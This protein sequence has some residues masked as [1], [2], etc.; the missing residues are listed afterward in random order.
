MEESFNRFIKLNFCSS[1]E[2]QEAKEYYETIAN[3]NNKKFY[4]QTLLRIISLSYEYMLKNNSLDFDFAYPIYHKYGLTKEDF[5][6]YVDYFAHNSF[7]HVLL[8]KYDTI[9]KARDNQI[10]EG[11]FEEVKMVMWDKK[12]I[13]DIAKRHNMTQAKLYRIIDDYVTNVLKFDNKEYKRYKKYYHYYSLFINFSGMDYSTLNKALYYYQNYASAKEK[14]NFVKVANLFLSVIEKMM[15]I[16]NFSYINKDLANVKIREYDLY[17]LA[18]IINGD[19]DF[20]KKIKMLYK[21]YYD[22]CSSVNWDKNAITIKAKEIN[23]SYQE[24]I[25]CAKDYA[26]SILGIRD[27]NEEVNV[28]RGFHNSISNSWYTPILEQILVTDDLDVCKKLFA[29]NNIILTYIRRF[30]HIVHK[31][32]SEEVKNKIENELIKK[33]ELC[34]SNSQPNVMYTEDVYTEFANSCDSVVDF[35]NKNNFVIDYFCKASYRIKNE[36]VAKIVKEKIRL[37]KQDCVINNHSNYREEINTFLDYLCNGIPYQ[38]TIRPL[39]L[40]DYYILFPNINY[41]SIKYG[42]LKHGEASYV[43]SFFVPLLYTNRINRNA[44]IN[45]HIDLVL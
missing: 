27:I 32:D 22:Y 28:I 13:R 17:T 26:T 35:C 15:Q 39:D 18:K 30:A 33:Y 8:R 24:Y 38:D 3:D 34:K 41:K 44:I 21:P 4:L 25:K 37:Y 45:S 6:F 2:F 9:M 1:K 14:E 12:A 43:R 19:E 31:H 11:Y 20:L 16:Y 10:K 29:E 5:L 23:I 7:W 40:I 42:Y 36:K